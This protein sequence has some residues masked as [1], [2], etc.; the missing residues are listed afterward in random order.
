MLKAVQSG[1]GC[2]RIVC[3]RKDLP[4]FDINTT[5]YKK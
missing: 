1:D 2:L 5:P 4:D 3:K